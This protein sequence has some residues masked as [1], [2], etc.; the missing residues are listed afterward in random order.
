MKLEEHVATAVEKADTPATRAI[1]RDTHAYDFM[2][3]MFSGSVAMMSGKGIDVAIGSAGKVLATTDIVSTAS[4]NRNL[5]IGSKTAQMLL[6]SASLL[7]L[8]AKTNPLI[9][10]STIGAASATKISIAFGLANDNQQ[11]KCLAAMTDLAAGGFNAVVGA[12]MISTG[13]GAVMGSMILVSSAAQLI[14]AGRKVHLACSDR[15]G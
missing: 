2:L 3:G 14:L 8:G 6:T 11:A 15:D 13:A 5:E 7:S 10:I 9:A 1:L 12:G 4:G